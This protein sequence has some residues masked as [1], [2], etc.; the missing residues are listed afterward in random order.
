MKIPKIDINTERWFQKVSNI[1]KGNATN[2]NLDTVLL[3][4]GSGK[5]SAWQPPKGRRATDSMHR[6]GELPSVPLHALLLAIKLSQYQDPN[7]KSC[8]PEISCLNVRYMPITLQERDEEYRK[9]KPA[10]PAAP[11]DLW[12]AVLEHNTRRSAL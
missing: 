7:S 10:R 5:R 8:P 2:S 3:H 4:H 11:P 6:T 12:V 1:N 9:R